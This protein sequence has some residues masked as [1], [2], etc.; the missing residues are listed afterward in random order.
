MYHL[1]TGAAIAATAFVSNDPQL[2]V[3]P[4]AVEA[5][6]SLEQALERLTRE[7]NQ[8]YSYN[9]PKKLPSW[10]TLGFS[11]CGAVFALALGFSV[12]GHGLPVPRP[13]YS[14]TRGTPTSVA[15]GRLSLL[16]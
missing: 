7:R 6:P 8:R 11:L 14:G 1:R 10:M 15:H 13:T 2:W 5:L 12:V 9:F 16:I 4:Q 3:L